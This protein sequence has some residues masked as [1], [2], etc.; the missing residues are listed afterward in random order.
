MSWTIW[1]YTYIIYLHGY[2]E[3]ISI[4]TKNWTLHLLKLEG[5]EQAYYWWYHRSTFSQTPHLKNHPRVTVDVR[6]F[7]S[8]AEAVAAGGDNEQKWRTQINSVLLVSILLGFVIGDLR[9]VN[10][11]L[12][13]QYRILVSSHW[14]EDSETFFA[15]LLVIESHCFLVYLSCLKVG[16]N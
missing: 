2:N 15:L 8:P 6:M 12:S 11:T 14:K 13:T 16:F 1:N 5:I 3:C 10:K 7:M 9:L 4:K